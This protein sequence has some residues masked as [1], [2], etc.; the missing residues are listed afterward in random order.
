MNVETIDLHWMRIKGSVTAHYWRT[1]TAS[2]VAV[3]ACGEVQR[4]EN[5]TDF[6]DYHRCAHCEFKLDI[7]SG[8]KFIGEYKAH[9]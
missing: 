6:G 2:T 4:K 1:H 3:S 9:D 5:L 8:N 7:R